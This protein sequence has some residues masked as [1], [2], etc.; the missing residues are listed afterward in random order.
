MKRNPIWHGMGQLDAIFRLVAEHRPLLFFGLPGLMILL[1]GLGLGLQVVLIYDATQ[2]L[3]IGYSM[4]TVLLVIVGM[5][6][7]FVGIMLHAIRGLVREAIR[8]T[9]RRTD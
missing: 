2:Q 8:D 1:A 9:N 6:A 4:I 3:A 7:T 5:L